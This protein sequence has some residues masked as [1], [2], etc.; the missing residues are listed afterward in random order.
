M[1][2]EGWREDMDTAMAIAR[3]AGPLSLAMTINYKYDTVRCVEHYASPAGS[4]SRG[5][6][7]SHLARPLPAQLSRSIVA[8]GRPPTGA[9]VPLI[10]ATQ[11]PGRLEMLGD[12]CC[13]LVILFDRGGQPPVQRAIRS[14]LRLVGN[15]TDQRMPKCVLRLRAEGD[16]ID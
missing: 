16:L 7:V 8:V 2:R 5:Q 10:C 14:E 11:I 1:G 13:V 9:H 15:S 3:T 4:G 6:R 12:Q